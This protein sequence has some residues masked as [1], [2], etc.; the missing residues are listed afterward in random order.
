MF[1]DIISHWHSLQPVGSVGDIKGNALLESE[2]EAMFV[3]RLERMAQDSGGTFRAITIG[4]KKG[5]F[6][7][8]GKDAPA[9][10]VEPQVWLNERF[11]TPVKTRADFLL[12]PKAAG[13]DVMPIAIYVDGWESHQDRIAS[14]M[15][16]R[17]AALRT[18]QCLVWSLS[19]YDLSNEFAANPADR[20]A[21]LWQPFAG[22]EMSY[23]KYCAD[24]DC[25]QARSLVAAPPAR[26]LQEYM[27]KPDAA[28]WKAL[29]GI[30]SLLFWPPR[31][32]KIRRR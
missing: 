30:L 26:A 8:L 5:Y 2:L 17:L 31:L 3:S 29:P 12:R 15:E 20:T 9:W 25:S 14:D 19:Y 13:K 21:H 28:L 11:I 18:G 7:K 32:T 27:T 4:G 1:T 24:V 16:K 10:E 22:L 6:I 23:D